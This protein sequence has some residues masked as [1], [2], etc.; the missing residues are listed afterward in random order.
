MLPSVVTDLCR[1]L[2]RAPW[3]HTWCALLSLSLSSHRAVSSANGAA[4]APLA[5]ASALS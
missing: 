4:V 2:A 1:S 3:R 5:I